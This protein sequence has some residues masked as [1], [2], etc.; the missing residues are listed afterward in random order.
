[1]RKL[2][3]QPNESIPWDYIQWWF[4]AHRP[5]KNRTAVQIVKV[6]RRLVHT[7]QVCLVPI[8][9]DWLRSDSRIK[10]GSNSI[11][12][13]N[14]AQCGIT[15]SLTACAVSQNMTICMWCVSVVLVGDSGVGKTN[16]LSRYTRNE[17]YLES[18]PTI[19]VEF[20]TRSVNARII[21]TR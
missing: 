4:N 11:P 10:I 3:Y 19:G 5:K 15:L 7:F 18:K 6:N 17:F 16:L 9:S 1:V 12:S 13:I 14:W 21:L 8:C 2:L 20:A